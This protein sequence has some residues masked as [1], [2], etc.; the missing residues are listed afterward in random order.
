VALWL[1]SITIFLSTSC[2]GAIIRRHS[3]DFS[4]YFNAFNRRDKEEF[5]EHERLKNSLAHFKQIDWNVI[6]QPRITESEESSE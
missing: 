5:A 2:E 1:F 3:N 4:P 6:V